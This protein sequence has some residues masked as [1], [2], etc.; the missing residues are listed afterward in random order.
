MLE[1]FLIGGV[2]KK[3]G[4][5]LPAYAL[6]IVMQRGEDV[7]PVPS[8]CLLRANGDWT[9][10]GWMPQ[11]CYLGGMAVAGDLADSMSPFPSSGH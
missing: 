5:S 8:G 9:G 3:A 6:A 7:Y 10:R 1:V 4:D 2:G 11:R